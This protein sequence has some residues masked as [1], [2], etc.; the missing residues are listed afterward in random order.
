MTA[1]E[2]A[3]KISELE[4]QKVKAEGTKCEVYSRVVG[5]L[6]PVAL[7][8]EGKK[9]EFKIRKSYCPCK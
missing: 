7:W 1:Q 2:I 4:K 9:E 5:Y 8:N 6:R 3:S